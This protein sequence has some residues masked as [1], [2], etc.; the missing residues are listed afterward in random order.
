MDTQ[1]DAFSE[2]VILGGMRTKNDVRILLCYILKSLNAPFSKAMLNEVLQT[3]ALANFFE[4]NDALAALT[5]GGFVSL[6]SR[7]DDDYYTLTDSG[8][9][10]AER[11]ETDLPRQVRETAVAAA[12][13][14]LSRQRVRYG[15]E[16]KIVKLEQGGYHVTLTI[17]DQDTVM[18]QTVLFAA[19]SLQANAITEAFS[20]D[21]HRLYSGVIDSLDL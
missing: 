9:V 10:I 17:K 13:E 4:V 6:L 20:A 12:M 21:P 7:E 15:T 16:T 19:D 14:L 8:R 1:Y 2:G 3:T 5:D 11:L 18:L